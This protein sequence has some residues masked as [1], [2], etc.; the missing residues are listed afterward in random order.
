M[1]LYTIF[2]QV[3]LSVQLTLVLWKS[4]KRKKGYVDNHN[5]LVIFGLILITYI[6]T[7]SK[8]L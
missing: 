6:D 4:L 2:L 7:V 5:V 3:Q 8:Q 1:I